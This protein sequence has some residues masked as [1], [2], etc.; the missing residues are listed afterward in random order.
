METQIFYHAKIDLIFKKIL[1][2]ETKILR[3]IT[4]TLQLISRF[5]TSQKYHLSKILILLYT[6]KLAPRS[7]LSSKVGPPNPP[8]PWPHFCLGI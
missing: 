3:D 4:I 2:K 6:E 1:L 7:L 8:K 5:N